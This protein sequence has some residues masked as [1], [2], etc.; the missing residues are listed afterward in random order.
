MINHQ[1]YNQINYGNQLAYMNQLVQQNVPQNINPQNI[2]PQ[3][4]YWNPT[5]VNNNS[6][7][8]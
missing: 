4:M 5:L 7:Q 1:N 6:L 3:L 2:N 8:E